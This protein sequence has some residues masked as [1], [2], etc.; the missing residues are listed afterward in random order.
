[1]NKEAIL[2]QSELTENALL[3]VI[4]KGI[5]LKLFLIVLYL[6]FLMLVRLNVSS[7]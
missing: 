6:C 3:Q 2:S 5:Y 4:F 7:F 1:M